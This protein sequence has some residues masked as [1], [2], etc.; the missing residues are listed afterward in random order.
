MYSSGEIL[1]CLPVSNDKSSDKQH[2]TRWASWILVLKSICALMLSSQ[3]R[4]NQHCPTIRRTESSW[5]RQKRHTVVYSESQTRTQWS[6]EASGVN[7][8]ESSL[9]KREP[10]KSTYHTMVPLISTM[11]KASRKEHIGKQSCSTCRHATSWRQT[12]WRHHDHFGTTG[13]ARLSK[14]Q[15]SL[16]P[17]IS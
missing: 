4:Q 5:L 8:G 6:T 15:P 3:S 13:Q 1:C 10:R 9:H 7:F 14:T 16:P 11:I 17:M 12:W 2:K